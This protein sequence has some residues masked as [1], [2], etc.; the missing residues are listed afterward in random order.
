MHQKDESDA[1]SPTP[2]NT[3]ELQQ[4]CS[5]QQ[6]CGEQTQT[7]SVMYV[8]YKACRDICRVAQATQQGAIPE[9][10]LGGVA[11][12]KLLL[13]ERHKLASVNGIRTLH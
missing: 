7:A 1:P 12:D 11:V 3:L 4:H 8:Q 2:Q 13:A 10:Y 6:C 9:V 5:I